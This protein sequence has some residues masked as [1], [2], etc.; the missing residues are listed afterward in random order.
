MNDKEATLSLTAGQLAICIVSL[1][2]MSQRESVARGGKHVH[3]SLTA[4][5]HTHLTVALAKL[6]RTLEKYD[7]NAYDL[8]LLRAIDA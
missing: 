4:E 1:T 5:E 7:I 2:Y 8:A 3:L 6:L